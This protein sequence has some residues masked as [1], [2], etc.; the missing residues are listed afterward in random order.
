MEKWKEIDKNINKTTYN[1]YENRLIFTLMQNMRFFIKRRKES[2]VIDLENTDKDKQPKND[3]NLEYKATSKLNGEN[4]DIN[5]TMNSS[6]DTDNNESKEKVQEII[7]KIEELEVKID[8]LAASEVYK[9]LEK[10]KVLLVREPIKK[11]NVILKNVNFQYAMKLWNYLRDNLDESTMMDEENN[12]YM[13]NGELKEYIDETFLLQ[14]LSM[15]TLDDDVMEN[16]D[17]KQEIETMILDQMIDKAL[18]LNTKV[19]E[20]E[21]EQMIAARYEV[22]KYKKMQAMKEIK[23]I[24]KEHFDK[25]NDEIMKRNIVND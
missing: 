15:K 21:L 22:I 12:D 25:Y 6:L 8:S 9:I 14:Y 18:D 23:E 10:E 7:T 3:K 13:D 11:T 17:T 4:V 24:F 20:A 16:R 5:I 1:T 2:L 19:T